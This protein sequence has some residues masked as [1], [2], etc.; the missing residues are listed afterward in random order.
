M[1][2]YVVT[3]DGREFDILLEYHSEN[4]RA[5]VNG[6]PTAI[7]HNHLG[8]NRF[9]LLADHESF[10]VDVRPAGSNGDRI[11]FMLGQEIPVQ[12]ENFHVA[13][14]RKAA[15][16]VAHA[17]VERQLRAPMPGL[18]LKIHV[19]PG[20]R[21]TKG[22]PL[23]VIEAMKMENIIKAKA[24]ATVSA[25]TA[26]VGRTVEKGDPLVEFQADGH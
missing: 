17:A 14:A 4:Y 9:L 23:V 13:Q 16:I 3:V 8:E 24:D 11:V 7:T 21:V 26:V 20:Q 6:R 1:A 22:Q 2:R 19:T 12:V 10:E 18:V 5:T 15:G 25:V